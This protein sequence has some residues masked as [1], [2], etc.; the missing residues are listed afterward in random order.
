MMTERATGTERATRTA[1]K[2]ARL[3]LVW[4]EVRYSLLVMSR[5]RQ[6]RFFTLVLPVGL[7][8]LFASI[9]GHQSFAIDG[10]S[11]AA[12]TYYVGNL[13]AFG[14]LD[15]AF[16]TV[17]VVIVTE[18]ESG[19]LK[20][21]RATPEP[22]WAV[23]AG[24][25]ATAVV[26]TLGIVV[27]LLVVGWIGYSAPIALG[28]LPALGAGVMVGT[29]SACSLAFALSSLVTSADSAQPFAT[30]AALPLCFVSGVF[31]PWSIVPTWM[32]DVAEIFPVRQLA[33]LVLVPLEARH[34]ASG[35]DPVALAV[36]AAWGVL[37]L[38]VASRRFSWQPRA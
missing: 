38:V 21:R 1:P 11:V 31:I 18:R 22:A 35:F 28:T 23:V 3:A 17:I 2:L 12:T 26:S 27:L 14:V 4:H 10:H 9:F 15:G 13:T 19:I 30:A 24:R 16:M 20:R 6:A 5:N 7:L 37:G 34:G 29:L 25:A 8:V 36:V 33:Q 32:R